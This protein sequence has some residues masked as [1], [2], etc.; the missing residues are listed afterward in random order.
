MKKT[1]KE[2]KIKLFFSIYSFLWISLIPC[3]LFAI[4][5]QPPG[6]IITQTTEHTFDQPV[7]IPS[8]TNDIA[9]IL[10]DIQGLEGVIWDVDVK[11]FIQYVSPK[12]LTL[13]LESPT[14]EKTILM[15]EAGKK[16][17]Q[18]EI[19]VNPQLY[20][21]AINNSPPNSQPNS[22]PFENIN[23]LNTNF[24]NQVLNGTL[25]D[26]QSPLPITEVEYSITNKSHQ[27]SVAPEGAL[28]IFKGKN[29]N[30]TWKLTIKS[31]VPTAV[32]KGYYEW[33]WTDP[34]NIAIG[35]CQFYATTNEFCE[36]KQSEYS[37]GDL[38]KCNPI[39]G[40]NQFIFCNNNVEIIDIYTAVEYI[41]KSPI[42]VNNY[43]DY[44]DP[45]NITNCSL[46]ITTAK[47]TH[48]IQ[49]T[50]T[51]VTLNQN[52][53][54]NSLI[55]SIL[56]ITNQG[57]NIKELEVYTDI[58]HSQ[59]GDLRISLTSPSGKTA[60]LSGNNGGSPNNVFANTFWDDQAV[61]PAT[62][63]IYFNNI[64]KR[65]L[66]PEGAL[67]LFLGENP[68][69]NWTLNILDE[70]GNNPNSFGKLDEW[71]LRL[72]SY[73]TPK[74]PLALTP[75][76][77][78][79]KTLTLQTVSYTNYQP[80]SIQNFSTA[81]IPFKV[82]GLQG[83]VWDV[84]LTAFLHHTSTKDLIISLISP[85]G[86]K[87]VLSSNNGFQRGPFPENYFPQNFVLDY[88][89][90]DPPNILPPFPFDNFVLAA[91]SNLLN[92]VSW[93]DQAALPITDADYSS[94][95]P[96][97]LVT[98]EGAMD[99][100][101]GI[102]PNG[103]WKL[104]IQDTRDN[105]PVSGTA[106]WFNQSVQHMT[107]YLTEGLVT[108]CSLRL[109]VVQGDSETK[110]WGFTNVVDKVLTDIPLESKL[111]ISG[112][113]KKLEQVR[114]YTKISHPASGNLDFTI[115]SP[116][117]K[118]VILSTG[119]SGNTPDAFLGTIWD[120]RASTDLRVTDFNFNN[121]VAPLLA[122]EGALALFRG[123]NPNGTWTLT[124]T[125]HQAAG[126]LG[127]WGLLITAY[128]DFLA[129]IVD[130]P[131]PLPPPPAPPYSQ[132]NAYIFG[133][134]S[135]NAFLLKQYDGTL[136]EKPRAI[137]ELPAKYKIVAANYF[138]VLDST[139]Q[140]LCLILQNK[141]E[142]IAKEIGEDGATLNN[143]PLYVPTLTERKDKI[144]AS[145]DINQDGYNDLIIQG[146]RRAVT[147]LYGPDFPSS[148]PLTNNFRKLGKVTGVVDNKILSRK[149]NLL[150]AT[151][152]P[153]KTNEF[154]APPEILA[155]GLKA[156]LKICGVADILKT[157]GLELVI[158]NGK[159]IGYGPLNLNGPFG[160]I[161]TNRSDLN[162]GKAV[163][164]R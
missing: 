146:K 80:H 1:P 143:A 90:A 84:D 103:D 139:N 65:S 30:G 13:T 107:S 106:K 3:R 82:S 27:A 52:I 83:S 155:N 53:F 120:D 108:N 145:G 61:T 112:V 150:Y 156:S 88:N 44:G 116:S 151:S 153:T 20:L 140:I 33:N 73:V 63:A 161:Y 113:G 31:G 126:I 5:P 81:M 122:P 152:L 56:T 85:D 104:E 41:L 72:T 131:P 78:P 109:T 4:S 26:D 136:M 59:P 132:G 141:N 91:Y 16:I 37:W 148:T 164:P 135:K 95:L 115:T 2:L 34:N 17:K 117:G 89:E 45:Q 162:M 55:N 121:Q 157:P 32:T 125:D 119:N 129:P 123:E 101:R 134:K 76:P 15:S 12:V 6:Q 49:W 159:R 74:P 142:L 50:N 35:P 36:A 102:D 147:I 160:F 127:E 64:A 163:G 42:Y 158:Q 54:N 43:K 21:L 124:V 14:G 105:Q 46:I 99:I 68:N 28:A 10:F 77:E 70:D 87:A 23:D 75:P 51:V 7:N 48:P 128:A 118:T 94:D 154:V 79:P 133:Q 66:I 111:S 71:G 24:Y 47:G 8:N 60:L 9:E 144:V 137:S 149:R 40:N 96:L 39:F 62:D 130:Y 98:P 97:G 57:K 29:P 11:T 22:F 67:A 100:F 86:K 114:V 58:D 110:D 25:W 138:S 69:G 38:K 18:K 93:N 92:G 19:S